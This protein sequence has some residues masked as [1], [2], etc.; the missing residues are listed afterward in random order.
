MTT[1]MY[2]ENTCQAVYIDPLPFSFLIICQ[3]HSL[4]TE[5]DGA[6]ESYKQFQETLDARRVAL[7][8]DSKMPPVGGNRHFMSE[9]AASKD[10]ETSML[11]T[12]YELA[13]FTGDRQPLFVPY[14]PHTPMPYETVLRVQNLPMFTASDRE[15]A[16]TPEQYE[17]YLKSAVQYL[18]P[19]AKLRVSCRD[20]VFSKYIEFCVHSTHPL[21]L[22]DDGVN[23][24]Y[25]IIMDREGFHIASA[26]VM[27]DYIKAFSRNV[28]EGQPTMTKE[29][30]HYLTG[31]LPSNCLKIQVMKEEVVHVDNH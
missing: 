16:T 4:R 12:R 30:R 21:N 2:F 28:P 31:G 20:I 10:H 25:P 3:P 1:S 8:D 14:A 6:K 5:M 11:W 17:V 27:E 7:K 18:V 26:Q 13:R 15:T 9:E 24:S 23:H 29:D 19:S 22:D